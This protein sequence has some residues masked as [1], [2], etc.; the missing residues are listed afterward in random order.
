MDTF[1]I[2]IFLHGSSGI[3]LKRPAVR[4]PP[5]IFRNVIELTLGQP[6]FAWLAFGKIFPSNSSIVIPVP[7]TCPKSASSISSNKIWGA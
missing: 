1:R 7:D 5:R 2:V 4:A 3:Q 6:S